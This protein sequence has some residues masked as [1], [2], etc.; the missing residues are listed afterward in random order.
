[1]FSD[2]QPPHIPPEGSPVAFGQEVIP[3]ADHGSAQ[4]VFSYDQNELWPM[5]TQE[6]IPNL[7]LD[8]TAIQ[9]SIH[10]HSYDEASTVD[11]QARE[12]RNI[13]PAQRTP[14]QTQ[15][16]DDIAILRKMAPLAYLYQDL[17]TPTEIRELTAE[18]TVLSQKR[19]EDFATIEDR[20]IDFILGKPDMAD[21]YNHGIVAIVK[22]AQSGDRTMKWKS[23]SRAASVAT[24]FLHESLG[25]I[26]EGRSYIIGIDTGD[27]EM[28][29][30]Y[31]FAASLHAQ[32]VLAMRLD[33]VREARQQM[34][35]ANCSA[36]N[37]WYTS[38]KP[39]IDRLPPGFKGDRHAASWE[40]SDLIG[41]MNE[42]LTS[43]QKTGRTKSYMYDSVGA[44]KLQ[45]KINHLVNA[46]KSRLDQYVPSEELEII[47]LDPE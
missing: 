29:P 45:I 9:R 41:G 22:K 10:L 18:L 42:R 3:A 19:R 23:L 12:A 43:T 5:P 6:E 39:V 7:K 16:L 1:M 27:T 24:I 32:K 40:L 44:I 35:V 26:R 36:I 2:R 11:A 4:E 30:I 20:A 8:L 33:A 37:A 38:V 15:L 21:A 13:D 17:Y 47:P 14:E 28:N 34:F 31:Q 25:R 46:I